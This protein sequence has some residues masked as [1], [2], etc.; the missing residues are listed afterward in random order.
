MI[1]PQF[2][3]EDLC[4]GVIGRFTRWKPVIPDSSHPIDVL[5]QDIGLDGLDRY[6]HL[7][8]HPG[9]NVR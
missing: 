9:R 6:F 7:L 5:I 4:R 2:N 3:T 1:I 8:H